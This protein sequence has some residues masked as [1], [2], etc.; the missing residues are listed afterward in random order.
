MAIEGHIKGSHEKDR[1]PAGD[2]RQKQFWRH[3]R[4]KEGGMINNRE[5]FPRRQQ[6]LPS[7]PSLWWEN[8]GWGSLA[9]QRGDMSAVIIQ[10]PGPH[11]T[12]FLKDY[13]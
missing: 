9:G 1:Y 4:K 6:W 11:G 8:A 13:L 7:R 3:N 10:G 2:G 12:C 5:C